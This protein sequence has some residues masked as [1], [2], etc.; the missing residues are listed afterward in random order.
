MGHYHSLRMKGELRDEH[1]HT[2]RL[3][4][5]HENW[6]IVAD[7]MNDL[8]LREKLLAFALL[9]RSRFI[10]FGGLSDAPEGWGDGFDGWGEL[11]LR[12]PQDGHVAFCCSVKDSV[13]VER[14]V[15]DVVPLLFRKV[16]TCESYFDYD[17]TTRRWQMQ[18]GQMEETR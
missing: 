9:E 11:G 15:L 6:F 1:I 12:Y 2:W 3:L 7:W 14:F 16:E 13:V 5:D 10:P 8:Q 4:V 18:G 17:N